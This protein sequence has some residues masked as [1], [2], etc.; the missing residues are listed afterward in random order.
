MLQRA[1]LIQQMQGS[2]C[3]YSMTTTG[4]QPFFSP[5]T[6]ASILGPA[7]LGIQMQPPHPIGFGNHIFQQQSRAI[8]KEFRRMQDLRRER[9]HYKDQSRT[10]VNETAKTGTKTGTGETNTDSTAQEKTDNKP[11]D[12]ENASNSIPLET[13]GV[14]KAVDEPQVKRRRLGSG[15]SDN[16]EHSDAADPVTSNITAPEEDVSNEPQGE[17]TNERENCGTSENVEQNTEV[18]NTVSTLKVTIQQS[19]ESRAI[20]TSAPDSGAKGSEE[21]VEDLKSLSDKFICYICNSNCHNQQNFQNHMNGTRH[22]Q[23]LL[24]IQQM[25]IACLGPE[26]GKAQNKGV[27]KDSDNKQQRWCSTCQAHF[28]GNVIEHRRTRRHKL[29]K[30]SLRPFCTVC[31]RYFKTPRKFVEHMKSSEHKQKVVEVKLQRSAQEQ[32][33]PD[34]PEDMITVD[35]V[36]CFDEDDEDGMSEAECESLSDCLSERESQQASL[37]DFEKEPHDS[38]A[39]YGQEFVVPVTGFLCKL[40][41]KFYHSESTARFTH[42][43]SLMHFQNLQNYKEQR[44]QESLLTSGQEPTASGMSGQVSA[45]DLKPTGGKQKEAGQTSQSPNMSKLETKGMNPK[46]EVTQSAQTVSPNVSAGSKEDVTTSHSEDAKPANSSHEDID[47]D[48]DLGG[49]DGSSELA[50]E[51]MDDSLLYDETAVT[52]VELKNTRPLAEPNTRELNAAPGSPV[53][54]E[55]NKHEELEP[56]SK[57]IEKCSEKEDGQVGQL[58]RGVEKQYEEPEVKSEENDDDLDSSPPKTRYGRAVKGRRCSLRRKN[59]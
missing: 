15:E 47:E 2:F 39:V 21:T 12:P 32:A 52:P 33:G 7:P 20:S 38:E 56:S 10:K 18:L 45:D 44:S 17:E 22:H 58:S 53:T 37:S 55:A 13:E 46:P 28:R 19:S 24:E 25:S 30:Y 23:R 14:S 49:L 8:N 29:A 27:D 59:K 54:G 36:G 41:H 26:E 4:I 40:C 31:S 43:K 9:F 50:D 11:A 5:A 51:E 3:G 34:D 1:L 35:A 57:K 48:I 16:P 42:C 6:R